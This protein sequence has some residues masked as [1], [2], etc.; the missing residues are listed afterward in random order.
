MSQSLIPSSCAQ[1]A[2]DAADDCTLPLFKYVPPRPVRGDFG[3]IVVGAEIFHQIDDC[4]EFYAAIG[5]KPGQAMASWLPEEVLWDR[6]IRDGAS[7]SGRCLQVQIT[8]YLYRKLVEFR[9]RYGHVY[10]EM[11]E[12]CNSECADECDGHRSGCSTHPRANN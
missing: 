1:A 6:Y 11:L 5:C 7:M 9:Q 2:A 3:R 8:A 10:D 12:R 4:D